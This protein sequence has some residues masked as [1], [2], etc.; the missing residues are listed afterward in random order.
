[1]AETES[2][3]GIEVTL[4]NLTELHREFGVP[5]LHEIS[6]TKSGF[7][8]DS[9]RLRGYKPTPPGKHP[10]TSWVWKHGE[11]V[12]RVSDGKAFWLCRLCYEKSRWQ[13]LVLKSAK[14]TNRPADHLCDPR[15][16]NFN[17]DG[18]IK[19]TKKRK[20]EDEQ[21][22]VLQQVQRQA[23]DDS[24]IFDRLGWQKCYLEWAIGDDISLRKAT[25]KRLKR[26]LEFHNSKVS[27]IVPQNHSTTARWILKL[28]AGS[29]PAIIRSLARARSKISIS[30]D[31]WKSDNELDLLGIFA[32]YL[33]ENLQ[34]KTVMLGLRNTYG[35][36]DGEAMKDELLHVIQ[37]CQITDKLG[38]FIADN[39]TNNDAAIRL[40]STHLD[41]NPKRQRLRCAAHII[42]LVCKAILYGVDVDCIDDALR[43]EE[44]DEDD[45]KDEGEAELQDSKGVTEFERIQQTA[46]ELDKLKA[47]RKR[48]PLGKLH[49]LIVH[50]RCSPK[51]R[52]FFKRKQKDVNPDTRVFELVLNGGIRWNSDH[53]MIERAFK[54]K[55][56]LEL[57]QAHFRAVDDKP[58]HPDDCLTPD[59]WT[60][61]KEL[62]DLLSPI[63]EA[64]RV[65]QSN[66]DYYGSLWQT[67][68]SI[69]W[70]LSE[71]ETKNA[72]QEF[73]PNTHFKACIKLGWKKLNKYYALTD[74]TPAYIA[75]VALHPHF[76][77]R[78]FNQHW[79]GMVVE[80][81]KGSKTRPKNGKKAK[82]KDKR[83]DDLW[84]D[85]ARNQLQ[86]IYDEYKRKYAHETTATTQIAAYSDTLRQPSRYEKWLWMDSEPV[87]DD[88]ERYLSEAPAPAGTNCLSW[89][90]ANHH[91]FPVLRHLAFDLL[92]A[93]SSSSAA[94]R[95]FSEAGHVLDEEHWHTRAELGEANQ[96]LKSWFGQDMVP[97]HINVSTLMAINE[98]DMT[99]NCGNP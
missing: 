96:C 82:A 77:M 54:V 86:L 35:N 16:H 85:R 91:R 19:E 94:E 48:G 62:C 76:K 73:L 63:K 43:D 24:T 13:G 57:Y 5:S 1:M 22:S 45:S 51:R 4:D 55:D 95:R 87:A 21:D 97:D 34:L 18:S 30:F 38:F 92:A 37:E 61:L 53:D 29:K 52:E 7:L 58:L 36:H 26:L 40:L 89:W 14:S 11:P 8:V 39:A 6:R 70:L 9:T 25:S 44:A 50:A 31:A 2:E 47:W 69:E 12:T 59:D 32:H 3:L 67:L 60:E 80:E 98:S 49:N 88:L 46:D 90:I 23:E 84:P 15:Y 27:L 10:L 64:S 99:H 68:T 81:K 20:R 56:A 72:E 78:F 71:L 93:P 41:I 66:G 28:F 75:S 79:Q 74:R 65:V 83:A 17:R 33:D 42:N